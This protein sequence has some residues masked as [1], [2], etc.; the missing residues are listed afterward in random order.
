MENPYIAA[1]CGS[2]QKRGVTCH[3][4]DALIH[5]AARN[6]PHFLKTT[7]D[8]LGGSVSFWDAFGLLQAAACRRKQIKHVNNL[9]CARHRHNWKCGLPA[10]RA[11]SAFL[12]K[13][14]RRTVDVFAPNTQC[15]IYLGLYTMKQAQCVRRLAPVPPAKQSWLP[16]SPLLAAKLNFGDCN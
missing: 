4:L 13:E 16:L 15:P 8:L 12:E 3:F 7:H 9:R 5:P 11:F 1:A 6:C 10:N 2:F 14:Q